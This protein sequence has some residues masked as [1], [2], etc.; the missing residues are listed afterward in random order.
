VS[1]EKS[2]TD[3]KAFDN[4]VKIFPPEPR[5]KLPGANFASCSLT[6]TAVLVAP[7]DTTNGEPVNTNA[8]P[9]NTLEPVAI[10]TSKWNAE[11]TK[12]PSS[13]E[14]HLNSL[15]SSTMPKYYNP[16]LSIKKSRCVD[17]NATQNT[18]FATEEVVSQ[19]SDTSN[20]SLEQVN[21]PLSVNNTLRDEKND[22]N[23]QQ[24]VNTANSYPKDPDK[25]LAQVNN[26]LSVNN[27]L[28]DEK[29]D[30]NFQ[31]RIA[32]QQG[33]RVRDRK[34]SPSWSMLMSTKHPGL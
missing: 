15:H 16:F 3:R 34:T 23:F 32:N 6:V 20:K 10:A 11:P 8:K 14:S 27:T 28:R 1:Q 17:S 5:E 2:T 4:N 22:N 30:N 7:A 26:P 18:P 31:Q 21:N 13:Q 25:S 24:L 29:N 12:T 9:V 19:Y 33:T